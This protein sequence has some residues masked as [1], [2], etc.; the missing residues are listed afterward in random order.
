MSDYDNKISESLDIKNSELTKQAQGI[1]R[2]NKLSIADK[3][4]E[5]LEE[6]NPVISDSSIPNGPDDNMS[7]DKEGPTPIPG[8]HDKETVP[9]DAYVDMELGLPRGENDSLMHAIVKGENLTM[10]EI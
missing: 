4:S 3:D 5:F 8:I 9:I 1:D 2:W 10:M 7:D 6:L